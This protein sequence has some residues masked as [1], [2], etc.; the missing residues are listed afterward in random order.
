MES[1]W[2][3]VGGEIFVGRLV[4][5]IVTG[6]DE[7]ADVVGAAVIIDFVGADE[8]VAVIGIDFVGGVV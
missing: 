5:D 2:T 6:M 3:P 7:G 4:P 8:G 1:S